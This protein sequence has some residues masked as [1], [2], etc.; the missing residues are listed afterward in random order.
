MEEY[1]DY[2][3]SGKVFRTLS[4]QILSGKYQKGDELREVTVGKSWESAGLRSEKPSGSWNW[5][6]W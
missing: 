1:Q 5:K 3:L 4:E 6:D 2:S